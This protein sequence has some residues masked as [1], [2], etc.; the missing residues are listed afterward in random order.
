MIKAREKGIDLSKYKHDL[1]DEEIDAA[2]KE[3]NDAGVIDEVKN[4]AQDLV[5]DSN[6]H[7][8]LLPPSKER[9]LL[10]EIGEFFITRSD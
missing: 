6:R 7:L 9:A 3:L 2:I 8:S 1:T 10:M 4:I 5:K